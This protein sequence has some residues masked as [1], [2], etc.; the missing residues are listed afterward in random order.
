[1]PTSRSPTSPAV[2]YAQ[3]V[4]TSMRCS[5]KGAGSRGRRN[6]QN[7]LFPLTFATSVRE[8]D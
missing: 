4:P 5:G 6:V 3:V 1:L 2:S 8:D 7:D